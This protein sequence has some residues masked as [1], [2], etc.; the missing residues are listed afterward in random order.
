MK[1]IKLMADY[2]CSPLW[3]ACG[4]E[5]GDIDLNDLPISTSLKNQLW[6]WAD[7][8]DRTLNWDDPATSGFKNAD[9]VEAFTADGIKLAD[10]LRVELGA[11]FSVRVDIHAYVKTDRI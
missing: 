1:T 4:E 11:D 6:S 8:Y 7:V 10:Q 3:H 5:V 9:E 2:E